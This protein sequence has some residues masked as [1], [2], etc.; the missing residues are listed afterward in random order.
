M[1]GFCPS[2][3]SVPLQPLLPAQVVHEVKME[4]VKVRWTFST[5]QLTFLLALVLKK[6]KTP[7]PTNKPQ[8][9]NTPQT[10]PR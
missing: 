8:T 6:Q 4:T 10:K 9:K 3:K 5:Q 1:V 2:V 7:T